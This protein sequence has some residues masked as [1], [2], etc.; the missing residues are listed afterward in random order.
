[1]ATSNQISGQTQF[2]GFQN[3]ELALVDANKDVKATTD[4]VL[5]SKSWDADTQRAAGDMGSLI[6]VVV[7]AALV[8]TP[9]FTWIAEVTFDGGTTWTEIGRA[10]VAP[11][12]TSTGIAIYC[13]AVG[14]KANNI[15]LRA[16]STGGTL[17]GTH[18]VTVSASLSKIIRQ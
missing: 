4:Y 11:S 17:D 15:R 16:D 2:N 18:Y 12:A 7:L 1:M 14:C 5:H 10:W 13:T 3:Y 6:I 9:S 8:S